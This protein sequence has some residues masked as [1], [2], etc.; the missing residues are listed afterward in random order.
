MYWHHRDVQIAVFCDVI[1]RGVADMYWH[2]RGI[3]YLHIQ[4]L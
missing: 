1:P 2:F 3:H 4:D